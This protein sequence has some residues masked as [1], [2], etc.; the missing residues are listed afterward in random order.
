[1]AHG[2]SDPIVPIGLGEDARDLLRSQGREVE[3]H[4]Y[5]MPHSVCAEEVADI[6]E[7]LLGVLP[8]R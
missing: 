1:M 2:T 4:A 8:V 5:P 6:R 3:W 7:W